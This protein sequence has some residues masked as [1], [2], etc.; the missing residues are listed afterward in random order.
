[1]GAADTV[2][3]SIEAA[4]AIFADVVKHLGR[5]LSI[6]HMHDAL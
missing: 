6:M 1:M 3:E 2:E 4:Y 5:A